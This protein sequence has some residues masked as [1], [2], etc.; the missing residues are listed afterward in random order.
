MKITDWTTI[1]ELA[2]IKDH[3]KGTTLNAMIS[4]FLKNNEPTKTITVN[5]S[6]QK[7]WEWEDYY[8]RRSGATI[9]I[10]EK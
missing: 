9:L 6:K 2:E 8:I 1:K 7:V 10:K 4:T 5:G 3:R